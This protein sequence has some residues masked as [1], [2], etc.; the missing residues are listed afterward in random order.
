MHPGI[1]TSAQK[2]ALSAWAHQLGSNGSRGTR[3]SAHRALPPALGAPS[4]TTRAASGGGKPAVGALFALPALPGPRPGRGEKFSRQSPRRPLAQPTA[5]H[6][7][8]A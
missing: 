7:R 4:A 3:S 5:L 6:N 8:L 2:S 1:L